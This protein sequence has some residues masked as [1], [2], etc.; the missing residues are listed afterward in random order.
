MGQFVG[1]TFFVEY[2]TPFLHKPIAEGPVAGFIPTAEYLF[3]NAGG[4]RANDGF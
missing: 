3:R 2:N 1:Y 4:G